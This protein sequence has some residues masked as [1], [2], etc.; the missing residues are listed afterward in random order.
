[1]S[2]DTSNVSINIT[3]DS[4]DLRLILNSNSAHITQST[5]SGTESGTESITDNTIE[6]NTL[7]RLNNISLL[8]SSF[9][10][11]ANGRNMAP[12]KCPIYT[13]SSQG[14]DITNMFVSGTC[15][16][17]INTDPSYSNTFNQLLNFLSGKY[18]STNKAV[19]DQVL[20]ENFW[21]YAQHLLGSN[22]R[23]IFDTN[24]QLIVN[25]FD[26]YFVEAFENVCVCYSTPTYPCCVP[27]LNCDLF[28]TLGLSI[29]AYYNAGMGV[30]SGIDPSFNQFALG[31]LDLSNMLISTTM[32]A[33]NIFFPNVDL[34]DGVNATHTN[35]QDAIL[36]MVDAI[37]DNKFTT[38]K[39]GMPRWYLPA[40]KVN[41]QERINLGKLHG[42]Y[43]D[44][45]ILQQM[46]KR[47]IDSGWCS[48][49]ISFV[50]F[51]GSVYDV[52]G[53]DAGGERTALDVSGASP[54]LT[55]SVKAVYDNFDNIEFFGLT[56][57][58]AS[59]FCYWE[60]NGDYWSLTKN[61]PVN[62]TDIS[63]HYFNKTITVTGPDLLQD[64]TSTVLTRQAGLYTDLLAGICCDGKSTVEATTSLNG[65][66]YIKT[67]C[68][69]PNSLYE[70]KLL[71]LPIA[72]VG[73]VNDKSGNPVPLAPYLVYYALFSQIAGSLMSS[74]GNQIKWKYL[75]ENVSK[76][77][78]STDT[79]LHKI[80]GH[81]AYNL[82]QE[83][84]VQILN[85]LMQLKN[86]IAT[87]DNKY[88]T[89]PSTFSYSS[90]LDVSRGYIDVSSIKP[91][92]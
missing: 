44:Y 78:N 38:D 3:G 11:T 15:Y 27:S 7:T 47:C 92:I 66:A 74:N 20:S 29:G 23:N 60:A 79:S 88:V 2:S 64:Q 41:L 22:S 36:A 83:S 49:N 31:S 45:A 77:F 50:D 85:R 72:D 24:S 40:N 62:G 75:L 84:K 80:S 6:V 19:I 12:L 14:V 18:S 34:S 53:S 1:M 57:L 87:S 33:I 89:V 4:N 48:P 68:G 70:N 51:I 67:I 25:N 35:Y 90:L 39:Y 13:A 56:C 61:K 86:G 9:D 5:E 26:Q 55:V 37:C 46:S 52:S 43:E 63:N 28:S 71:S 8:N 58:A 65:S 30:A 76:I 10:F 82:T 73:T 16:P 81:S 69:I 32:H 59:Q 21:G 91:S 17:V 42:N 54:P